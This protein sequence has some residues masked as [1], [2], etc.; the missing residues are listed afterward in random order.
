MM[1]AAPI[2]GSPDAP[3]VMIPLMVCEKPLAEYRIKIKTMKKTEIP[4]FLFI[5][6]KL[7]A[8]VL[9]DKLLQRVSKIEE[10]IKK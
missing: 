1:T 8:E 3:S 2:S 7:L 9:I 5:Q 6:M 4:W 10:K